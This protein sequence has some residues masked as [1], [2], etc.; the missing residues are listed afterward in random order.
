MFVAIV[1]YRPWSQCSSLQS[2]A[3]FSF[4]Q[5]YQLSVVIAISNSVLLHVSIELIR[6]PA[7]NVSGLPTKRIALL[8][9][10]SNGI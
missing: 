10:G 7:E 2:T 1:P 8:R 9:R 6:M 4:S 3:A 5:G